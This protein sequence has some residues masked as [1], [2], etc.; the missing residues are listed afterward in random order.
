MPDRTR[1][2]KED[3]VFFR[4]DCMCCDLMTKLWL[5]FTRL[6][7]LPQTDCT[8]AN[9]HCLSILSLLFYLSSLR[10]S[11]P[12]AVFVEEAVLLELGLCCC[13]CTFV[14]LCTWD[15]EVRKWRWALA[16]CYSPSLKMTCLGAHFLPHVH[17]QAIRWHIRHKCV[18]WQIPAGMI[19]QRVWIYIEGRESVHLSGFICWI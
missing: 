8:S 3:F 15:H 7:V 5:P 12:T 4:L 9:W 18:I 17:K 10:P 1:L 11:Q 14:S 19:R 2:D 6:S 13:G 16:S